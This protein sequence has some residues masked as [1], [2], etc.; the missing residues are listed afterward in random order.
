MSKVVAVAV[1]LAMIAG[2]APRGPNGSAGP[3]QSFQSTSLEQG[4]GRVSDGCPDDPRRLPDDAVARAAFQA[5]DEVRHLYDDL[6]TRRSKVIQ[7][8]RAAAAGVRGQE[9]RKACGQTAYRRSV[10]V[11]LVFPKMRPSA[12]LSQ[13][14]VFVS[15]F[16]D[17]YRVWKVAH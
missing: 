3:R 5:L 10:V 2:C 8:D 12:S 11:E 4:R 6:D 15:R 16:D 13:G 9:I 17:G 7:S 14:T 1:V